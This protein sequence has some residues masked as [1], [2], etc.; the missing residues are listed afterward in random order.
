[1]SSCPLNGQ[2]ALTNRMKS[3]RYLLR[4]LNNSWFSLALVH[5]RVPENDIMFL[6]LLAHHN[7]KPNKRKRVLTN[8]N[9]I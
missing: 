3:R 2:L 4:L 6:Y 7:Y 1:M 9:V 8:P 5:I